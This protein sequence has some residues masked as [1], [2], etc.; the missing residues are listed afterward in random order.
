MELNKEEIFL[1]EKSIISKISREKKN[2]SIDIKNKKYQYVKLKTD[3]IDSLTKLLNKLEKEYPLPMSKAD[4][5][6]MIK[7]EYITR[8][9]STKLDRK[10]S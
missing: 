8:A 4:I 1:I 2:I 7:N 6:K 9:K 5:N 10:I 3:Y